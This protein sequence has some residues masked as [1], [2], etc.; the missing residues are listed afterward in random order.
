LG[1]GAILTASMIF[2]SFHENGI[3]TKEIL[4]ILFL[5]LTAP[6]SANMLAKTALHV[7]MKPRGDTLNLD[8]V[9]VIRQRGN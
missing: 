9:E 1:I 2:F 5:F 3:S 7:R 4:I 8:E 6:I